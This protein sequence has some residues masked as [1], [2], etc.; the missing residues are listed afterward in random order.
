MKHVVHKPLQTNCF[1]CE[2]FLSQWMSFWR[3]RTHFFSVSRQ[4]IVYLRVLMLQAP[5]SQSPSPRPPSTS[6]NPSHRESGSRLVL[7]GLNG[8]VVPPPSPVSCH[9]MSLDVTLLVNTINVAITPRQ[10]AVSPDHVPQ[11][12]TR[13]LRSQALAL[14]LKISDQSSHHGVEI[15]TGAGYHYRHSI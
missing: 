15:V 9:Y 8:L 2:Q 12:K 1:P 7:P 4:I 14:C 10:S 11:H 6:F 5:S 13:A 3:G